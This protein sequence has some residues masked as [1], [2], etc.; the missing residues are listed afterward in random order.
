MPRACAL[1]VIISAKAL[2]SRPIASAIA[3]ATSLAERV[4]IALI[5]FSTEIVSPGSRP[6]FEGSC[7][8]ACSEI[9]NLR[10]QR[11]GAFVELLEQ[12]IERHHLGDRGGVA[13][14]VL[15][16]AVE[17]AP[18]VGVDDDGGE[19]GIGGRALPARRVA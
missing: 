7:A 6:S 9:G 4:T 8:A 11:Q 5:A 10:L 2:S 19:S 14:V 16:H 1:R 17:R 15:V 13:Q 18:G 3:T 12:K